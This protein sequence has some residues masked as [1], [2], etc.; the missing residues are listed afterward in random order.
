MANIETQDVVKADPNAFNAVKKVSQNV[1]AVAD[2]EDFLVMDIL[3]LCH[4]PR[5]K[6]FYRRV[7][8]LC[9]AEMVYQTLSEVKDLKLTHQLRKTPGAAFTAIIQAKAQRVGIDLVINKQ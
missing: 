8:R 1:I 7:A 5:S 6:G 4:D 3:E 9:P 2:E